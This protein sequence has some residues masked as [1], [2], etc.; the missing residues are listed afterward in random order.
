MD[1]IADVKEK[2]CTVEL[3]IESMEIDI[4]KFSFEAEKEEKWSL[5]SKANSYRETVKR[6]KR[7]L[8]TLDETLNKLEGKL[9]QLK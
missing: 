5:L 6:K 4:E 9:H 3:C 1:K 2:N 8:S 7:T